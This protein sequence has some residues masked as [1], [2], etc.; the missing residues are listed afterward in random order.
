VFL[1][2]LNEV[3]MSKVEDL[4]VAL[5]AEFAV[6]AKDKDATIAGVKSAGARVRKATLAIAKIGKELRTETIAESK[7]A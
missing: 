5:E 6:I 3:N 2:L 7:T 1:C 4:F